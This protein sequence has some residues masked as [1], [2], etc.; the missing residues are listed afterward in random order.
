MDAVILAA[1]RGQR[2]AGIAAPFHKVLMPVNGRALVV[3]AVS[4][5][6]SVL[7]HDEDRTVIVVAPENALP[8]TA[9]LRDSV[10]WNDRCR[11]VVQPAPCGPGD[12]LYLALEQL[13]AEYVTVICADNVISDADVQ[14]VVSATL[15]G[16]GDPC[17]GIGV[18]T[19]KSASAVTQFTVIGEE[20]HVGEKLHGSELEEFRWHDG[21]FRAWLGPL[22]VPRARAAGLLRLWRQ[23]THEISISPLLHDLHIEKVLVEVDCYDIGTPE[24]LS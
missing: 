14:K 15:D 19:I 13:T 24:A 17:V 5:G 16:P 11:I 12:A 4:A 20:R 3:G 2:L 6:V 7:D 10:A 8:I 9:L 1:G 22:V 21:Y 18:R 23:R